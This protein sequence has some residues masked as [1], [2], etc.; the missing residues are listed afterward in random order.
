MRRFQVNVNGTSYDVTVEE[1]GAE[2][3]SSE[4]KSFAPQVVNNNKTVSSQTKPVEKKQELK[5]GDTVNAPMPGNIVN[6]LVSEG[7]TVKSGQVL[8]V[9]EAMKMENEIVSPKDAKVAQVVVSK[10]ASVNTGDVLVVL[11]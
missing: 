6:V 8:V 7:Q 4:V 3:S 5:K 10:G 2:D 11:E 1:L 9:L